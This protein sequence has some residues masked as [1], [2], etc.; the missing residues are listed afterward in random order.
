MV[1][2]FILLLFAF[3]IW[4][5]A[6]SLDNGM[7]TPEEIAEYLNVEKNDLKQFVEIEQFKN[8]K[9]VFYTPSD[10][11]FV[12]GLSWI[13]K[14]NGVWKWIS[15]GGALN[16]DQ[17][18]LTYTWSNLDQMKTYGDGAHIFWG[19]INDDAISKVHVKY[20]NNWDLNQDAEIIEVG[21]IRVW[22]V[23][24]DYYYGTIP[25]VDITGYSSLGEKIYGNN[26]QEQNTVEEATTHIE[27]KNEYQQP[28]EIHSIESQITSLNDNALEEPLNGVAYHVWLHTDE[29]I[30]IDKI[31]SYEFEIVSHLPHDSMIAPQPV[32][33][34][35]FL[36]TETDGYIFGLRFDT[37]FR[38]YS[39]E[40]LDD[41]N[42]Y[43]D[44]QLFVKL[45]GG[46]ELVNQQS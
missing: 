46:R 41:L 29:K 7:N 28:F 6:R 45:E 8:A 15:G 33:G 40:E 5:V 31:S 39:Q 37:M 4:M 16:D 26:N 19:I 30:P 25:G 36:H 23:L 27:V 44:F 34:I 9:L 3:I 2:L 14:E 43:R 22:Y 10:E 1:I 17:E 42:A 21:D 12:A 38:D 11:V 20:R 13:K 35:T 32:S 24:A 18:G